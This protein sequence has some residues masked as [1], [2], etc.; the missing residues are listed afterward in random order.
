MKGRIQIFGLIGLSVLA[1]L[2]ATAP[3][4]KPPAAIPLRVTVSP[5]LAST[6]VP[7]TFLNCNMVSDYPG[8][9]YEHTNSQPFK[10]NCIEINGGSFRMIISKDNAVG[11]YMKLLFEGD[12]LAPTDPDLCAQNSYFLADKILDYP[13]AS[14]FHFSTTY[15]YSKM[16]SGGEVF[17]TNT[18]TPFII[19]NMKAGDSAFAGT[20]V[21]FNIQ[22]D[23]ATDGYKENSDRYMIDCCDYPVRVRCLNID[24]DPALE[25]IITPIQEPYRNVLENNNLYPNGSLFR[26]LISGAYQSKCLLGYF[27]FPFEFILDPK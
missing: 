14:S 21:Y 4:G 24:E 25:W 23:L 20:W 3:A 18:K 7:G 1:V 15:T 16:V 8:V 13:E 10:G 22:D 9:P 17:L 5:L 12:V 6:T 11:R 26:R 2:I 19:T 27:K